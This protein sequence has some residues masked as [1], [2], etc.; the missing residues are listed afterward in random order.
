MSKQKAPL[1]YFVLIFWKELSN[2]ISSNNV[3]KYERICMICCDLMYVSCEINYMSHKLKVE[4][5]IIFI[6]FQRY[7]KFFILPNQDFLKIG[8]PN[9][10]GTVQRWDIFITIID[11][12]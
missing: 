2:Y 1:I 3:V 7:L 12:F 4:F 11:K 6:N 8:V 5:W 9:N 10:T